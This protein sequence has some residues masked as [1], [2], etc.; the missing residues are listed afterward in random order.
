MRYDK[1]RRKVRIIA[2][3]QHFYP[4]SLKH[5]CFK[6]STHR[7]VGV[8]QNTPSSAFFRD[9]L[10]GLQCPRF[11]VGEHERDQNGIGGNGGNHVFGRN[12]SLV[13]HRNARDGNVDGVALVTGT[14][15]S[16][17]TIAGF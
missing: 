7:R 13:V 10:D 3:T 16:S 11:V 2:L 9:F 8:A 4:C 1:G 17:T 6:L 14:S 5:F 12:P 15:S